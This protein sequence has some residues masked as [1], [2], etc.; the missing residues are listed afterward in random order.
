MNSYC[1]HSRSIRR[2]KRAFLVK[3]SNPPISIT[4]ILH[5]K[6]ALCTSLQEDNR[7]NAVHMAAAG[8]FWRKTKLNNDITQRNRESPSWMWWNNKL[9][10]HR[11][12]SWSAPFCTFDLL[13]LIFCVKIFLLYFQQLP[14]CYPLGAAHKL[15]GFEK[16]AKALQINKGWRAAATLLSSCQYTFKNGIAESYK[17]R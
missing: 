4:Y 9:L 6:K 17:S 1:E 11:T 3:Y 15:C 16:T 7:G 13:K 2:Q 5:L 12:S 14:F 8:W 10:T